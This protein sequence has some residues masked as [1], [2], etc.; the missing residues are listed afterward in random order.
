MTVNFKDHFST[1]SSQ[2]QRFRPCYPPALFDWLA[3]QTPRHELAW[4]CATGNGQAALALATHFEKVIA[5]DASD[6][7][8]AQCLPHPRVEYRVAKAEQAP[9]V[10]ASVDLI[11]VAQALHWFDQPAFFQEAWRVLREHGVLAVWSYKLLSINPH[12]D[13]IVNHF[14]RD[15]VGPYWPPERRLVEQGYPPLP[16]PFHEIS[17]PEFAMT[18]Q[19]S[20][21]DVLGYLGT[22]SASIYYAQARQTDPLSQIRSALVET[23]GRAEQQTVHWPLQ[24]R[25]AIKNPGT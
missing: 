12:I 1:Q 23:W 24:L 2:Y 21:D 7:Q 19:W 4:D 5:S 3:R 25:V 13:A 22:W 20:L 16:P 14:Y 15:I 11:S 18:S 6:N 17:T 8:V 10:D 9:F